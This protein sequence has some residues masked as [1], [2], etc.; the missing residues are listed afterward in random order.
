MKK[1]LIIEKQKEIDKLKTNFISD[2]AVSIVLHHKDEADKYHTSLSKLKSELKALES[3]PEDEL[4]R[5]VYIKSADDLPLFYGKYYIVKDKDRGV[6]E[7]FFDM[8]L[9]KW[10]LESVDYYLLPIK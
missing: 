6:N 9:K 7:R 2:L 8:G 5:K 1:D 10:W 4:Y 3:L